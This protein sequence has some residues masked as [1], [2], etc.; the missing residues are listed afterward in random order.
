M[1][2]R[3]R[4]TPFGLGLVVLT[5][6]VGPLRGQEGPGLPPAPSLA[7]LLPD[8]FAPPEDSLN[9]FALDLG[10][11]TPVQEPDS[12]GLMSLPTLPALLPLPG[13]ASAEEEIVSLGALRLPEIPTA[14]RPAQ[15]VGGML[16]RQF[17]GKHEGEWGSLTAQVTLP[18]APQPLVPPDPTA[19]HAWQTDQALRLSM[20][21]PFFVYGNLGTKIDTQMPQSSQVAGQTGLACKLPVGSLAELQVRSGP[22]LTYVDPLRSTVRSQ[23]DWLLEIQARCPLV[24]GVGLEYQGTAIPA[25]STMQHDQVNQDVHLAIP[26]GSNGKVQVGAKQSWLSNTAPQPL[27]ITMQL[28]LGVQLTH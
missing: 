16:P 27:A 20:L 1:Q 19:A 8:P 22:R 7:S 13:L 3:T 18:T 11:L 2:F 15:D 24:Y 26:V 5:Y 28:Y 17:N 21:G 14:Q 10:W 25:T 6:L 4:A 9:P 23:S 12:F